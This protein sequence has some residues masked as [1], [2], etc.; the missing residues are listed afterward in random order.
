[1]RGR[2]MGRFDRLRVVE[3]PTATRVTVGISTSFIP[4]HKGAT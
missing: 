3:R 1:M 4:L 2:G